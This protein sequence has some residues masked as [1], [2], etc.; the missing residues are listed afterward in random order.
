MEIEQ[1]GSSPDMGEL[2]ATCNRT[3]CANPGRWQVG[4]VFY[5][6]GFENVSQGMKAYFKLVIC[7][8]HSKTARVE[9]F[10]SDA[11]WEQI[12]GAMRASGKAEPE[13]GLTKLL[14]IANHREES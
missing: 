8:K 14:L 5:A 10:L 13:R 1:Y 4:L 7:S 6:K 12:K 11:G 9:D 3:G 2:D